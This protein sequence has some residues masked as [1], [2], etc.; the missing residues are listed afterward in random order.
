MV[1]IPNSGDYR[2]TIGF[3]NL[4]E[5]QESKKIN[6]FVVPKGYVSPPRKTRR[7][8]GRNTRKPSRRSSFRK[9]MIKF[10]NNSSRAKKSSRQIKQDI[11]KIQQRHNIIPIMPRKKS[12]SLH[13]L[14]NYQPVQQQQQ[15]QQQQPVQPRPEQQQM[16]YLVKSPINK[17]PLP[18]HQTEVYP[19]QI[20]RRQRRQQIKY[21]NLLQLLTTNYFI[22]IKND[23]GGD[24]FFHS[25]SQGLASSKNK[26]YFSH[27]A[28]RKMVSENITLPIFKDYELQQ[29]ELYMADDNR[30]KSYIRQIYGGSLPQSKKDIIKQINKE[31]DKLI[32]NNNKIKDLKNSLPDLTKFNDFVKY[33]NTSNYWADSVAVNILSQILNVQF[34]IFDSNFNQIECLIRDTYTKKMYDGYILIWWTS[35]VHYELI[36]YNNTGFFTFE[37]LPPLIKSMIN[38]NATINPPCN[39]DARFPLTN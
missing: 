19:N 6:I 12:N 38:D 4:L 18:K 5:G 24:C 23:G 14:E 7:P 13:K 33:V 22:I 11:M 8:T 34:V 20:Y 29:W 32:Y 1:Y 9:E 15:Q 2:D 26:K 17:Q 39:S 25:V 36:T 3:N 16:Q 31:F 27:T 28:L 21:V 35:P 30:G 37:T 10:V